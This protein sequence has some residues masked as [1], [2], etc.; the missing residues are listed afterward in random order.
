MGQS[1]WSRGP[2]LSTYFTA[3]DFPRL[4]GLP[5]LATDDYASVLQA[6]LEITQILYNA[7]GILYSSTDRTLAL[8][9]EGDYPRYLDDF[10]RSSARWYKAWIDAEFSHEIKTTLLLLYEY[11]C[12]Y[13]NAFSFQAVL[14]RAL[15]SQ[16]HRHMPVHGRPSADLFSH[17]LMSSP[18]GPYVYKAISAAR[19]TLRLVTSLRSRD[20]LQYLPTRYFL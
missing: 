19:K 20:V 16:P 2:A 11:M 18:D 10:Q 14:L 1:F 15:Q 17:G 9:H 12:L 3:K 4:K 8:V 7:H 6:S 5:G 13:V